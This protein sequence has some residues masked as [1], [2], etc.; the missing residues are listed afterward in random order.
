[1][2]IDGRRVCCI[3]AQTDMPG[4]AESTICVPME[5]IQDAR[6]LLHPLLDEWLEWAAASDPDQRVPEA[7]FDGPELPPGF[8]VQFCYVHLLEAEA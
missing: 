2:K 3:T 6:D 7:G 8:R 4:R 1:V 5:E